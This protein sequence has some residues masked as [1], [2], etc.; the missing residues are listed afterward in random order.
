MSTYYRTTGKAYHQQIL[1]TVS[2]VTDIDLPAIFNI[3]YSTTRQVKNW[4]LCGITPFTPN[5]SK[6]ARDLEMNRSS[7]LTYLDYLDGASLIHVLD[8]PQISSALAK[9]DKVLIETPICTMP[10]VPAIRM[11]AAMKPTRCFC[12]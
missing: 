7:V 11:P 1:N 4:L 12:F 8:R 6:L 9:P 5:I 3:D 10:F 2:R